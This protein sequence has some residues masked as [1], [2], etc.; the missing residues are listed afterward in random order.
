MKSQM[1]AADRSGALFAVIVGADE[2]A[3]G[4]VTVRPLR[5]EGEQRRVGRNDLVPSLAELLDAPDPRRIQ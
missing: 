2:V 5:T 4:E 1:K 3:A